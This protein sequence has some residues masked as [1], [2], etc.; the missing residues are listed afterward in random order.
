MKSVVEGTT[1]KVLAWYDNKW[2]NGFRLVDRCVFVG[3]N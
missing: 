2:G 1:V 3:N